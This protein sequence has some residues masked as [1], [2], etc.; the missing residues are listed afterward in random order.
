MILMTTFTSLADP[1]THTSPLVLISTVAVLLLA[2]V[3]PISAIAIVISKSSSQN[4]HTNGIGLG[5]VSLHDEM[6]QFVEAVECG[7]ITLK[8]LQAESDSRYSEVSPPSTLSRPG[9]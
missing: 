5:T 1:T 8:S 2:L 4:Q 6:Q 7:G 3:L 9:T